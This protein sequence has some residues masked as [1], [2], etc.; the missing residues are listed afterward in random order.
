MRKWEEID[1]FDLASGMG[2][3]CFEFFLDLLVCLHRHPAVCVVNDDNLASP[4]KLLRDDD[5]AKSLSSVL[6]I[7]RCN[8]ERI[9]LKAYAIP[10][11]NE[12][13]LDQ[14]RESYW[15]RR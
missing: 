12:G 10:P 9:G 6:E 7:R 11:R 5:A 14:S 2:I 13:Q 4:K 1:G 8:Q 3:L 15:I